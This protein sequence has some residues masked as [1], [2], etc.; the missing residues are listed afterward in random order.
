MKRKTTARLKLFRVR[1]KKFI[2]NTFLML[3]SCWLAPE[4]YQIKYLLVFLIDALDFRTSYNKKYIKPEFK[5]NLVKQRF[6]FDQKF[7]K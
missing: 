6:F 2:L 5:Y 1:N 4:T 3:F 7:F